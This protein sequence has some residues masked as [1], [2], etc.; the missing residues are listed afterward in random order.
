MNIKDGLKIC[1][2]FSGELILNIAFIC[3]NVGIVL[4]FISNLA[5]SKVFNLFLIGATA[6]MLISTITTAICLHEV[7]EQED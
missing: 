1:L 6:A 3:I 7:C 5:W 2:G 4:H